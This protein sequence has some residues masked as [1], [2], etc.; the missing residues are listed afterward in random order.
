MFQKSV[1]FA[2]LLCASAA[3]ACVGPTNAAIESSLTRDLAK[4]KTVSVNVDDCVAVLSGQVDR[5][6]DKLPASKRAYKYDALTMVVNHIAVVTPVVD[7]Q[8]LV[9]D[10]TRKLRMDRERNGNLMSFSVSAHDG[11]VTVSGLAYSPMHR[12]DVLTLV[13]SVRGVRELSDAIQV[14]A[15]D[16]LYPYLTDPH[17][18]IYATDCA[19]TMSQC[20]NAHW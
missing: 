12:D 6:S 3:F 19:G 16:S 7:D 17:A 1:G 2:L 15:V 20:G 13:A 14:S 8:T 10:I 5:L 11:S 9:K 18:R 4:Y